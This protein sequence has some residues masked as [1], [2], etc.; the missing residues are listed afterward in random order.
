MRLRK[1]RPKKTEAKPADDVV[2]DQVSQTPAQSFRS[3]TTPDSANNFLTVDNSAK[4]LYPAWLKTSDSD[5][6]DTEA[7]QAAKA[8]NM[9]ARVRQSALNLLFLI[10]KVRDSI[11]LPFLYL[12][13]PIS[14][15]KVRMATLSVNRSLEGL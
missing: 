3:Y 7:G 9:Q 11:L 14:S 4:P 10:V 1:R 6:S 5:F 8:K 13:F 12:G 2:Q 15:S